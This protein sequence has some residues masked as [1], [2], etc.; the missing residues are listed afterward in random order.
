MNLDT[1]QIKLH[2][3][4]DLC[5]NVNK[6]DVLRLD[7]IHPIVSGNKWFKLKYQIEEAIALKHSTIAT[8]GGAFSNHIVA[9]AYAC[10]VVGIN[11]IGYIRGEKLKS[12]SHTLQQ[13]VEFGMELKFLNRTD[14]SQKEKIQLSGK[15]FYWIEE[16]GYSIHGAKGASEILKQIDTNEYSHI[17]CSCGTGTMIAGLITGALPHQ[18]TIGFSALKGNFE[19][20]QNFLKIIPDPC[21]KKSF[22]I[23]HDYHF[24]GYAK[25]P[26]ELLEFMNI[27]YN[28][29]QLPTDIVYTSKLIYGAIDLCKQN[30]FYKENKL[31]IIHSGGLQGNLSLPK[32]TLIF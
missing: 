15:N 1:N 22:K 12:L 17:L 3:I 18:T 11:S 25:H 32:G 5:N 2:S 29:T 7:L 27:I 16:G 28:K 14:Y 9:T 13:A 24:G 19:L 6:A 31:L 8:F 23:I 26:K 21:K 20:E 30:Y 4:L 10:K